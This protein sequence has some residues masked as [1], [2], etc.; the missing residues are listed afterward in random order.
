MLGIEHHYTRTASTIRLI[1]VREVVSLPRR[2]CLRRHVAAAGGRG[3]QRTMDHHRRGHP[4]EHAEA[5]GAPLAVRLRE[6]RP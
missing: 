4:G 2:P 6:Q 3:Q 5:E 1:A